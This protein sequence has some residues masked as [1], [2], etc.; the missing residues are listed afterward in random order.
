MFRRRRH[1]CHHNFRR[2]LSWLQSGNKLN[3][4]G[5]VMVSLRKLIQSVVRANFHSTS[6]F[7]CEIDIEIEINFELELKIEIDIEN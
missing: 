3:G 5:T 2:C 6:A 4:G 1:I 7:S